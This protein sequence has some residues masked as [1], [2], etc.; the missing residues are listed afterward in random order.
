MTRPRISARISAIS[1]SATLAVDAKA[2]AMKAAGRPVIGFG[3]GEP[4]FPTPDYIVEAAVEACRNPRFHKYTPAGGLPELKQAIADKT[5]RDSGFRVEAA[6]IL[7]TNGGKQAVYEAFATLLDPGDEVLVVAPYWTTYPEAI[8]LAGGVQVDV[9]TD[10]TTGY[11]ASVEQLEEKLTDRTKVLL[12]VSPSNPT[13]AVYSPAQVEEIGRWALDKGLWVVTDEIYE[14]LV[15]GEAEFSSIATAVPELRDRVVVLNGVAKTY[16]MTGWRVG[17]LIGPSDVVK[18]ATN[19]QSHAT[20]N[21]SNVAQAAALA[22]VSGDLSAVA[23]M[24]A[25][26]DRR[27]Q[28]M[29]RMLNEIPGVLCPEPFGAFYAYPSVKALLGKEIR[30]RRPQTSAELAELILEE[31][32]VALVPGEAFGTPG[33]FRLSYALGDDDLV[34]G[35]SRVAKLLAESH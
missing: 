25:A 8:K 11:L 1:E 31:A 10:E 20:S 23:E 2:K 30:G 3:A 18:A 26:F 14:H 22:A 28:T 13:G 35:V 4:D 16:A 24:R 15:Y 5:L 7:V 12:F 33:Y 19:L 17:W 21:V 27:R 34:E 29:V 6:Q 32:E 9:V